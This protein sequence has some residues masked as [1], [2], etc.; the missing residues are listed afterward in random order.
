MQSISNQDYTGLKP[1]APSNWASGALYR[2]RD[3][4]SQN[5][6][7]KSGA[8]ASFAIPAFVEALGLAHQVII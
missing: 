4:N 3:S 6:D 2:E 5:P 7:S 1:D 8:F